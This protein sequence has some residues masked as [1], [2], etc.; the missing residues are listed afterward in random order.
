MKQRPPKIAQWLLVISNKR[1]N[2]DV[3]LGDFEEFFNEIYQQS[4][5]FQARFWYWKQAFKSIPRLTKTALCW[6]LDMLKSYFKLVLRN[7]IKY[8]GYSFINIAGLALGL[9]L[10]ILIMLYVNNE[11]SYDKFN[12]NMSRIYRIENQERTQVSMA[13]A[14]GK[15]IAERIPE[16]REVVRFKFD[17]DYLIK[18]QP[19][20][21]QEIRESIMLPRFG[22]ADPGVFEV[23]TLP[24]TAGNPKTALESPFSLVLT[25]SVSKRLFGNEN[26]IGKMV[27]VNNTDDYKVTGVM[28]DPKNFHLDFKVLAS[29]VTLGKLYG[30]SALN[31]F[32]SWNVP[33]YV[34]LPHQHNASDVANKLTNLFYERLNKIFQT[35]FKFELFPL[36]N[37]YFAKSGSGKHGNLQSV[38]IFIIIA[39]FILI[40]ACINFINLS[41]ARASTRAREVGIKKVVGS[42]KTS[43]I[44]QFLTESVLLTLFALTIA[45]FLIYL[46]LP[47]FN[48][49]ISGNLSFDLFKNLQAILIIIGGAILVGLFA[50]IYPAFYLSAF[51]P[52]SVL[53]G[54][55]TKGVKSAKFRRILIVFQYSISI[56]MIIATIIVFNQLNYVK[57]RNLGFNKENILNFDIHRNLAIRTNKQGFKEILMKN[58]NILGVTFSQ[59]YP[60]HIFN[61]EGFKY[62]QERQRFAPVYTVDPDYFDVYG[63]KIIKGRSFSW[64]LKTAQLR[65]CIIN[66]A[67]LKEFGIEK[68]VGKMIH[69]EHI[70][71]SSFS[72]KDIEIIGVV[73]DF[74]FESL[75]D[76]ISPLVFGWNEPWLWNTS[77]R[78]SSKNIQETIKYMRKVWME[79][80]PEFPFEYSFLDETFNNQYKTEEKLGKIFRYFAMFGILIASLGLFGLVSFTIDK[81]T[82]EIG[83]RKVLGASVSNVFVLISKEFTKLILIANI[84][85]W[86]VSYYFSR[87]WLMGF[88]YK[89]EITLQPFLISALLV[90][91]ISFVTIVYFALKAAL[92]NPVNSLK[93]E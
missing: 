82:K 24:F 48:N 57:N 50:G 18:Y 55:E 84:F 75:H 20:G 81:R 42:N 88:S 36:N 16:T 26:P 74:H 25:E 45:V 29:F 83:I 53:K 23:F 52:C 79:F 3:V 40:I 72:S 89:T 61:N 33:T 1:K 4:G 85:A 5:A 22:W 49:L 91:L 15:E 60:G 32:D 11:L 28:K 35:E 63:L 80:S 87:K 86:P 41:T 43:L 93:Y 14:V 13:P 44:N 92:A 19:P 21:S 70:E 76:E 46:L 34:L 68:P 7:I 51:K 73:K 8:K 59:G 9:T 6:R 2:R 71:G 10:F 58:P 64:D 39:L 37:L 78:I 90:I 69:I 66:E 38:Y 17:L 31:S 56:I 65:T 30:P 27:K 62:K 54:E 47:E 12:K 67:A 77:V